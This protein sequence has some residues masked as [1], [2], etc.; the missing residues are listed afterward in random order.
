MRR[1]IANVIWIQYEKR[2]V[3][4][5]IKLL[6]DSNTHIRRV[7]VSALRKCINSDLSNSWE[8]RHFYDP[9]A[10]REAMRSGIEKKLEDRQK[11]YQDY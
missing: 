7:G 3:P 6:D 4:E 11:D 10:A 1:A 8:N 9:N 5:M 2:S